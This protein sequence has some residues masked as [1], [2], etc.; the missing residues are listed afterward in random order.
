[1]DSKD[2][3]TSVV[4]KKVLRVL[5]GL[6]NGCEFVIDSE[7]LLVIVGADSWTNPLEPFIELPDDTLFIPQ[8]EDGIN[9]EVIFS[10]DDEHTVQLRELRG[11][12]SILRNISLNCRVQVGDIIF[13]LCQQGDIWESDVLRYP[14]ENP[15]SDTTNTCVEKKHTVF[16]SIMV[17]AVLL[18]VSF[19][20]YLFY[21]NIDNHI[22]RLN[23]V[24]VNNNNELRMIQGSDKVMYVFAEDQRKAI[25]VNQ[26]IER[27]DHTSAVKVIYPEK[28]TERIY[29]WLNDHMPKLKYFRLQLDNALIPR[30]LVSQQRS[31]LTVGQIAEIRTQLMRLMPY[32]KNLEVVEINDNDLI[33]Q[34][35]EALEAIGL[36][37]KRNKANDYISYSVG[38]EL[39]D[40]ELIRL[41]SFVD[42]FYH[43]WGKEFIRFNIALE[44]DYLKD[45]SFSYGD[46]NYVKSGPGQWLFKNEE[47]RSNL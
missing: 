9:F 7:R 15:I 29:V 13:A 19:A 47:K 36:N 31:Q 16:I 23:K 3:T 44:D 6:L 20:F 10:L 11:E 28:E 25:W 22:R 27:G 26:A 5:N 14:I 1:M 12:E 37:F 24:L 21:D 45:K 34:A 2:N 46:Y 41:Q 42:N 30:L 38:G 33:G 8:N 17:V 39:N 32:V 43:Q 40:S 35:E 18:M 4:S